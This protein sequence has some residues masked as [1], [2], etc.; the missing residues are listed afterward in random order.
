MYFGKMG[1][2]NSRLFSPSEDEDF[3]SHGYRR[4]NSER[5]E[6]TSTTIDVGFSI[7]APKAGSSGSG[8]L[9][10][11]SDGLPGVVSRNVCVSLF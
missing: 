4:M 9:K 5:K 7:R 8:Q 6:A 10:R 1:G 2:D 3:Y 11:L